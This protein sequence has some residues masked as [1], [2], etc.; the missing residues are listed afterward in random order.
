MQSTRDLVSRSLPLFD[1][2][3]TLPCSSLDHDI[4]LAPVL[5]VRLDDDFFQRQP[6]AMTYFLKSRTMG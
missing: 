3:F 5:S 6:Q 2:P 1:L 4:I